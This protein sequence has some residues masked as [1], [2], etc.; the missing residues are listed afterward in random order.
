MSLTR[1]RKT[2]AAGKFFEIFSKNSTF[3]WYN[4]GNLRGGMATP[5]A[6]S[7]LLLKIQALPL[8]ALLFESDFNLKSSIVTIK[9]GKLAYSTFSKVQQR[10]RLLRA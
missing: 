8:Y 7:W 2:F 4:F 5:L 9:P 1:Y 6:Q 3:L 10:K